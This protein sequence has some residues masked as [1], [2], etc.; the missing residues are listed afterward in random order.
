VKNFD[1]QVAVFFG[2]WV[3]LGIARFVFFQFNRNA[4]LKKKVFRWGHV[5]MD[6][7]L[8]GFM[9]WVGFPMQVFYFAIPV[10]V[11]ITILN[12]W[13]TQF[14]PR[15]GVSFHAYRARFC[16]RCGQSISEGESGPPNTA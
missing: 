13:G 7:L 10:L 4:A 1:A 8:L 16:A 3:A 6:A 11:L 9:G 12:I 5:F 2:C 14:C 15:C